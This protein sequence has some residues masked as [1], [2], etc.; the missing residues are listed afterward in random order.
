MASRKHATTAP[1]RLRSGPPA[2]CAR[3]PATD[4]CGRS[5][6][7]PRLLLLRLVQRQASH[8]RLEAEAFEQLAVVD[9]LRVDEVADRLC[10]AVAKNG[11][12]RFNQSAAQAV[13]IRYVS[14]D[15]RLFDM[16]DQAGQQPGPWVHPCADEAVHV[17]WVDGR[18]AE[19]ITVPRHDL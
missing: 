5:R 4:E 1:A 9:V 10:A 14:A 18:E 16:S 17:R 12:R 2:R 6:R 13:R 15:V 11:H 19:G 3:R 8:I 7:L